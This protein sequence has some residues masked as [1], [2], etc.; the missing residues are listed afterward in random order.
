MDE[1]G[2]VTATGTKTTDKD[3]NTV[4]LV[5][6]DR[7][8]VKVSKTDIADGKELPGAKIQ[9]LDDKGTVVEEWTSEADDESTD[10][11][12]GIHEI[13][14]LKTGVTYTL[15]ETVAPEGYD[16]ATDT[17]FTID[18]TGEVTERKSVG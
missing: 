3:G 15:R 6:D 16:I 1:E 11:N 12:E 4:L 2:K 9:I 10:E 8:V 18:E 17:T 14:G 13:V 7:T 5:E